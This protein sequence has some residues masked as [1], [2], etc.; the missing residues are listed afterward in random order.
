[1][2]KC[3][4]SGKY[5]LWP[6]LTLGLLNHGYFVQLFT[7]SH[8]VRSFLL[9]LSGAS[10]GIAKLSHTPPEHSLRGGE[11]QCYQFE[12]SLKAAQGVQTPPSGNHRTTSCPLKQLAQLF[13]DTFLDFRSTNSKVLSLSKSN[14]EH[15]SYKHIQ[16]GCAAQKS[17]TC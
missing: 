10:F 6:W 13:Q 4:T 8:D 5:I 3:C 12:S 16:W 17:S 14:Q 15:V 9:N 2:E 1:M 7:Q 11:A